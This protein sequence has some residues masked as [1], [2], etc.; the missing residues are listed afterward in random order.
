MY[1]YTIYYTILLIICSSKGCS[2]K[3]FTAE[4][5]IRIQVVNTKLFPQQRGLWGKKVF[6]DSP[7][8][9]SHCIQWGLQDR[10]SYVLAFNSTPFPLFVP[11]KKY[12]INSYTFALEQFQHDYR[13]YRSAMHI[14]PIRAFLECMKNNNYINSYIFVLRQYYIYIYIKGLCILI[15]YDSI[16]VLWTRFTLYMEE[17]V[18]FMSFPDE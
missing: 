9:P 11:L 3:A 15:T 16:L 6:G 17:G 5:Q 1:I 10:E 8:L 18:T 13:V 7:K 14:K 2:E 4:Y 12:Y